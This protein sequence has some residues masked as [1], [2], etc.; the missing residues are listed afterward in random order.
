MKQ[1]KEDPWDI[2]SKNFHI[3][4]IIEGEVIRFVPYG[5]FM[6]LYED[7]NVLIHISEMSN[8]PISNSAEVLKLGQKVKAKLILLDPRKRKAGATLKFDNKIKRTP[9]I[10]PKK[11]LNNK[12]KKVVIKKKTEQKS[13]EK[14]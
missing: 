7:I 1:L 14:S 13:D 8:Q 4:D 3:G 5:A 12:H 2:I 11:S 10:T 9:K 6:R